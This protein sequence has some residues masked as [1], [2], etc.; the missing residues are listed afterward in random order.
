[1]TKK[2]LIKKYANRR[3]YNTDKSEYVTLNQVSDLIREGT[4]V[5][6]VDAK[7]GEDVTAFIL[8]QIIVEEAKTKNILLPTPLLHAIIQYGDNIL[9]EFFDKYLMKTIDNYLI[10]KNEM[11]AQFRKWLDLSTDLSSKA[12]E[13]M[14][15]LSPFK[16]PFTGFSPPTDKDSKNENETK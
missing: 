7:S 5:K 10:Y 9:K 14:E 2:V 8:T 11:D 13:A 12:R 15:S 3:L 6:V 4:V 16:N 1:M